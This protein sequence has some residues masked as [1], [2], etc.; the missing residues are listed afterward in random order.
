[1]RSGMV[2]LVAA[3][4]LLGSPD[5]IS[6]SWDLV[7][8]VEGYPA[9]AATLELKLEGNTV[10]GEISSEHTGKGKVT[11]GT[12]VDGKLAFTAV[13]ESHESIALSGSLHDGKLVGEFRTEGFVSRWEAMKRKS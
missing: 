5:P 8:H 3:I 1:M 4:I 7:F 12:W 13:F 11:E 6:G 10:T 9:T 2:S